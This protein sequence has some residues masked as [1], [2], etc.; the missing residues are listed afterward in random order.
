M[1]DAVPRF[2]NPHRLARWLSEHGIHTASWG[3][4]TY[5]S[6]YD[7]WEELS[8]GESMLEA[9]PVRRVV[10]V[11]SAR[12][13]RNPD[14]EYMLVELDQVFSDG[15][16]RRRGSPPREKLKAGESP[17]DGLA[18][19]LL[20]ELSLSPDDYEVLG[21]GEPPRV[22]QLQSPSY[23]GLCSEYWV[24]EFEVV[25]GALPAND[26][27]VPEPA[28]GGDDPAGHRFGWRRRSSANPRSTSLKKRA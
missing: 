21:S 10:S 5:K 18:R 20:E 26:F 2:A 24:Y 17:H 19:G 9:G 11:A 22:E 16:S 13:R 27:W 3:H 28:L 6:I 15:R 25:T 12:I 7:L 23:P 1:M 14:G 8:S 4:G